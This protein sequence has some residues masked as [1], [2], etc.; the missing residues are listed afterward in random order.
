MMPAPDP[1]PRGVL[2]RAGHAVH[3]RPSPRPVGR[4]YPGPLDAGLS[5]TGLVGDDLY[6]MA[7]DDRTGKPLLPPR[8][9]GTG[10]AGALLAELML[11]RFI[12]LRSDT[13]VVIGQ[14]APR[15]A[16]RGHVLLK[17]IAEEPSPLPV[18]VWLGFLARSAVQDVALRLEQAG[19]V[20]L[21]RSR[22]PGRPGRMVP[23]NPDWAFAP[24]LRVRSALDS[25]R[26]FTP[27][28]AALTGL[29]VACGLDFR[30]DQY[31]ARAGRSAG[32]AVTY[33]PPDLRQLIT[34]T[35]IIVSSAVLSHRT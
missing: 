8:P 23:V 26:E 16:V 1:A 12:G 24:M 4:G 21:V 22:V 6:L 28:A 30:L 25:A 19:Y 35:Q 14:D 7:H 5:G 10:L 33:L 32:D 29:A 11:A 15:A 17:Q 2:T 34:Q 27:H 13:A 18:R 9:L 31:Q 20:T 3:D